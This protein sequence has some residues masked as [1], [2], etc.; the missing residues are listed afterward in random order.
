MLSC[1]IHAAELQL[2]P[3]SEGRDACSQNLADPYQ[4]M[5]CPGEFNVDPAT[6]LENVEPME[7]LASCDL[8]KSQ[9][10]VF[11]TIYE[12]SGVLADV[13][14]HGITELFYNHPGKKQNSTR[15]QSRLGNAAT[16]AGLQ[17]PCLAP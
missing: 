2:Q 15:T 4:S 13:L 17:T 1:R 16:S 10:S 9:S 8:E 11:A 7:P 3:A 6:C 12:K 14:T 5:P